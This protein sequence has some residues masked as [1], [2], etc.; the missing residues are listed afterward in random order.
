MAWL[1]KGG[2]VDAD[3]GFIGAVIGFIV[4]VVLFVL[5]LGLSL[6]MDRSERSSE[7][8]GCSCLLR[9]AAILILTLGVG[10][11]YMVGRAIGAG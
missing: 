3:Y 10:V 9:L 8:M 5:L 2:N 4:S 6:M 11:G 1:P 7:R